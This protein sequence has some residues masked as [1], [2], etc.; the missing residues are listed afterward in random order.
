MGMLS[1][2]G[3]QSLAAADVPMDIKVQHYPSHFARHS[4]LDQQQLQQKQNK[5]ASKS[6]KNASEKMKN[7]ANGMQMQ[8]T[9]KCK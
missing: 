4:Q 2:M 8:M 9:E 6:Q 1:L 5:G 7:M 3:I